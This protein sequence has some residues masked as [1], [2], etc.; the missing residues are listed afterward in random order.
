MKEEKYS[1]RNFL[2]I[3]ALSLGAFGLH[4]QSAT[5]AQSIM[6]ALT[7]PVIKAPRYFLVGS[8]NGVS[9]HKLPDDTSLIMYQIGYNEIIN[10]YDAVESPSGPYWNPIWYRVWGG[11]VYSGDLYEVKY[12]LNSLNTNIRPT[13]QLAEVTVPYTRSMYYSKYEGWI[14]EYRLYYGTTHW[15]MDIL[16]GP[17]N[18]PWYKI[19]DE[20]NSIMLYVP[21]EHLRFV[22]DL[23]FQPISPEIPIG[24][25]RI[26]VSI[27]FQ[28][29]KAFEYD[30]EIFQTKISTG[31]LTSA[32][33]YIIQTK[34]PSKHMG[35]GNVTSDIYSYE[36]VG[37]PW[38]CFFQLEDG[39]ATHGTYW[40]SNFGTPMS[41]GCINM[42]MADAKWVY[43]WT[44]PIA[45]PEDWA[46]PGY[47]TAVVI[48]P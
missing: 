4:P 33:K 44:K 8:Q 24:K 15:V 5:P 18:K 42:S 6:A 29:L 32:G 14:P 27:T 43:R 35:N 26:E 16:T 10:V 1:R 40:H 28:T 37:V 34:M 3:G 36:L 12:Q 23:E 38:N 13:G 41:A 11:Y 9:V 20:K 22:Q 17:D 39:L 31:R 19:K 30:N 48:T 46:K 45:A 21:S 2:K 7:N 25:K 47:G